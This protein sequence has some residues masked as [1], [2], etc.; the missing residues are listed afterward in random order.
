MNYIVL[1]MEWN[2][3]YSKAK[4]HPRGVELRGDIIQIGAVK[5]NRRL[6]KTG[7]L[8]SVCALLFISVSTVT[9]RI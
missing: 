2:Q 6:K 8:T 4:K 1:D 7:E 3:P 5:L 9:S